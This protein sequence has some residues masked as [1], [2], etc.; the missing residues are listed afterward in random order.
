M[1]YGQLAGILLQ[2]SRAS[3]PRIES[4]SQNDDFTWEVTR[5]PLSMNMNDLVRVG[6][7]P[8]SKLPDTASSYLEALAYLNI[9]HLVHQRNDAWSLQKTVDGS[10]W[11]DDCSGSLPG[12][13]ALPIYRSIKGLSKFGVMISGRRMCSAMRMNR[14]SAW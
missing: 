8:R 13:S 6:G 11:R 14:L 2:L 12:T 5:R 4:L 9:E 1:L 10:L 3:I 7:F